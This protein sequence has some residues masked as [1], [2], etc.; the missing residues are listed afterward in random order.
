MRLGL[1]RHLLLFTCHHILVD[2]WT[3][4]VFFGELFATYRDNGNTDALP[5]VRPY[6]DYLA[7]LARQDGRA[8]LAV[9]RNYLTGFDVP[10]RL[11]SSRDLSSPVAA[12]QRWSG[13][14]PAEL[15]A[16]LQTMARSRGLTLNTVVQGLWGVLLGRLTGQDDV[17]FGVTVSGR[18]AELAGI[19]RMVGLF[20]NTVPLRIRL[21]PGDTLAGLLAGVQESQSRL[22]SFQHVGLAE[23]QRTVGAGELFDTLVVFENFPEDH[24]TREQHIEGLSVTRL[25]GRDATHYPL[26]LMVEPCERLHL[27]LDYDPTRFS[28]QAAETIGGR[29]VRL[30]EQGAAHPDSPLHTLDVLEAAERQKLVE[31]FNDTMRPLPMATLPELFEVQVTRNS[32][33]IAIVNGSQSLTFGEL[34]ARANR[35]AHFLIGV[36]LGPENLIGV[37]LD[38]SF[39]MATALFAIWKA[40]QPICRSTPTIPGSG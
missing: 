15:T 21:R 9:W 36:G 17:V 12:P 37:C 11:D 22:L 23:I 35:L 28:R 7:W 31:G 2:G 24:T 26:S 40:A 13:E 27:R 34:N 14:L 4:P 38:R 32:R 10:T 20:I 19:E 8:A 1:E 29:F 6:A 39:D 30:L 33:A 16:D 25:E 5:Q 3:L 18:P